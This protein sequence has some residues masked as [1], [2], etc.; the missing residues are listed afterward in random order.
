MQFNFTFDANV[1]LEQRVGFEMAA[2][3]WSKLLQD[4]VAV[5]LRIGATDQLGENGQ[6]VGGAIPI[7]HDTHYGTYQQYLANDITTAE[8][9]EVLAAL[10]AG[11]TVDVSVNGEIVDGNTELMLTRAQAKALGMEEAL[12][13]EDGQTWDRDV[14]A[15]PDGLDGYILINTSFDWHYDLTREA[16]AP[17]GTLDFL[18]MALHEIGHSL[19]FV[20]GL[21]GLIDTF[22]MHSGEERT[23][24]ITSLDL[25]RHADGDGIADLTFGNPAYFSIDGG[26]TNLA[27]FEEGNEYQASHWQ[28]YQDALGI[29]DPTLGYQE[30]TDISD[31]DLTAL[32]AIGWDVDYETL[33]NG[34]DLDTLY[35]QAQQSVAGTFGVNVEA[36]EAALTS[37]QDWQSLGYEAWFN[38]FK[39]QIM[40]QGWGTWFQGFDNQIL[41]QGWGTWFAEFQDQLLEQG[42]GTWFAEF[43]D[44]LLEQGWGTWFQDLDLDAAVL[45][46]LWGTWFQALEG[47]VFEQ[48]W[49][50]WFQSFEQE[51]LN[52]LWGTWFQ[53]FEQQVL[54]QGWGTWF[55]SFEADMLNQSWGT[56]FQSFEADM[57]NQSWGTWFQDFDAELLRQGWG[58]WFQEFESQSLSQVWGTWFQEMDTDTLNQLWGT[59]FQT[60]DAESFNQTWGT[61]FQS[62]DADTF[63]QMWGTWFQK[64]DTEVLNQM[65]GT[66]FQ[67]VDAD[68]FQQM[69]GTWFQNVD[70]ATLNQMWGTWFQ[71]VDEATL[72][73]MWGTWFQETDADTFQQM[74][75]TWFQNVDEATLNQMWGTWFQE[76]DPE[77]FQQG[78]GTWFQN[79]DEATLNQMWGTWFQETDAAA[80]SQM[81]GTWFQETDAA[82]FSQMWGTWFQTADT[83]TFDQMWGTWFQTVDTATFN[84]MWGTWFQEID[85]ATFDQMW[86]TWFQSVD[87]ATFNQMWGTW[88]Q[89]VDAD[90]LNQMWGTW[91]QDIDDGLLEQGW[92]TWFQK[93][94]TEV[95]EQG[96]GTWFQQIEGHSKTLDQATNQAEITGNA[97]ITGGATDDI[98]AGGNINDFINGV[99]GD[100]LIDGKAGDDVIFGGDGND[101]A[102]GW[103]GKD[104]IFGGEG[105]DFIAGENEDDQLY[106]EAGH[107]IMAGGRGDDY[108]DGGAGRDALKGDTGDDVLNGGDGEDLVD[109]GSGADLVIGGVGKDTVEGGMGD[110]I[111]YG[112]DYFVPVT[113][114]SNAT[115][116]PADPTISADQALAD[117]GF[118]MRLEA[119]DMKLKNYKVDD[120]AGASGGNV[121]KTQGK[122]RAETTFNGPSGTYDL[123]V[124]YEDQA[125]GSAEITL[126][127]KGK[128]PKQKY[129]WRLDGSA[130]AGTHTLSGITL[131]AG[132]EITLKGKSDRDT[133][134][135]LLD[136]LDIVTPGSATG[137]GTDPTAP[138]VYEFVAG[139]DGQ[140]AD[141]RIETEDMV[142]GGGYTQFD[143]V[144]AS[145]DAVVHNVTGE[146]GTATYTYTGETGVYNLYANYFDNI[147]G[148][149][150]AT[151]LLNGETLHSWQFNRDDFASHDE[152]LGLNVT[153]NQGD[154]IEI[155]GNANGL[156]FAAIDYITLEAV[157]PLPSEIDGIPNIETGTVV[158]LEAEQM[159]V[160]GGTIRQGDFAS[161]GGYVETYIPSFSISSDDD[162]DD[163]DDDD[164]SFSSFSEIPFNPLLQATSLFSGESGYYN[165]VVG[166]YDTT[167]GVAEIALS[168]DNQEVDR[169]YADQDF[170]D[171][172]GTNSLVSRTVAKGI[173]IEQFDLIE[174]SAIADGSDTGNIDYIQFIQVEPPTEITPDVPDVEAEVPLTPVNNDVIRGGEGHDTAYGGADDDTIYG[175]AGDDI[176]YGDFAAANDTVDPGPTAGLVGHW[177]FDEGSGFQAEDSTGTHSGTLLTYMSDQRSSSPWTSGKM[178]GGLAF[179]GF[180]DLVVV[181]D[182]DA[183]NLSNTLTLATWVK[184]D[185]FDDWNGLIVK[186]DSD[187]AYGLELASNGGLSFTANYGSL[188]G[189]VGSGDWFSNGT[190]TTDQWHHVAVTYDGS[191][192]Q[193]YID[194]ELDSSFAES[195]LT[196]GNSDDHLL[197]GADLAGTHFD[198][199][200]DDARVYNRALNVAEI[201]QLAASPQN[202]APAPGNAGTSF[203]GNDAL[204]FDHSNEMLINEGTLSFSFEADDVNRTQGLFSKDSSGYDDGGHLNIELNDGWLVGR[205]QTHRK[206]YH[207]A[208]QVEAGQAYDVAV[209]FG[210]R[211]IE[212]WLNGALVSN[213]NKTWGLG[214]NSGGSGN[215]EPIVLGATQTRSG[216]LVAD[217]LREYFTGT[218]HNVRLYDQQLSNVEIPQLPTNRASSANVVFEALTT[219]QGG[220][221]N[222]VSSA[223]PLENQFDGDDVRIFDHKTAM[224]LDDGTLSFRFQADS[225]SGHQGLISKDS[226]DYDDGGHFTVYLE[227]GQLIARFQ[228]THQTYYTSTWVSSGQDYDVAIT[229][230]DRGLELWLNG[231]LVDT[232]SYTGGLGTSAGGS[233]NREPIV[234]G[235]NQWASGNESADVLENHFS[236]TLQNVRLY[237]QQLSSV[238]IA[239][240]PAN[241]INS[242]N[243]VFEALTS[244]PS[245]QG[246]PGN[247]L[248]IGGS[249]NDTLFGEVGDDTLNGT[250]ADAAGALEIDTLT[251]GAGADVFILGDTQTAYYSTGGNLDY[252][253]ITDFTNGIDTL[254]L[255]GSATDYQQSTQGSDLFL[256]YGVDLVAQFQHL[257]LLDLNSSTTFV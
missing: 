256:Y 98:L 79:V 195:N 124:G 92:G 252:A 151:V 245:V 208:A 70:E 221:G 37:G 231:T 137:S 160:F 89:T 114:N 17:E 85:A 57:L 164:G 246:E 223:L 109:G 97:A 170:A 138:P 150:S 112:D 127:V 24:G 177:T 134:L 88:F 147:L 171:V 23:E 125:G 72:N 216:D 20:S 210:D 29:M 237:D 5:N 56:W 47:Q 117:L 76:T 51:M 39:E 33:A 193:F 13:L 190:I 172:A 173:A 207:I 257:T 90:T 80:F 201:G 77:L 115:N 149:A 220:A 200:L 180:N 153:L 226:E 212:L 238:E 63:S 121:I 18:T 31:L 140:Q 26:Q 166:Y 185:S 106:G 128:G 214:T 194:G 217:D 158:T 84:Q 102:Y 196:F 144:Y 227:S 239:Q 232:N 244:T 248:I 178:G 82:A 45:D 28:R 27:E 204:V 58:T 247:D 15:N 78:W 176:L 189:A 219:A 21:D 175:E 143:S 44:Q 251:G 203:S 6:A 159:N 19:G 2:A 197:L 235:A 8:D 83:A 69:W 113:D 183:L 145:G 9:Q 107:D 184:A 156:D 179:N 174:L 122:G 118:A 12:V 136:Y 206:Q 129:T 155:Q 30:R 32:D 101:I 52:Q 142:L 211:G 22:T 163:D 96:W 42:W 54:E 4:D 253:V 213:S 59:W 74:W 62:M 141:I 10:Q 60:A 48:M 188:S 40:E 162:G 7:F 64:L 169:W 215:R 250:D 139:N 234:L 233:G 132:D 243:V 161:G 167:G 130:G 255:H 95:L 105:D 224:L 152:T 119:E 111:L 68:T 38:A 222:T 16:D 87:E 104:T 148:N 192:V 199:T 93:F 198:G 131:E 43:Q 11:N 66:W 120:Q 71:S 165:I 67:N 1:S 242:A 126:E 230:G 103:H 154:V 168:V 181:A 240:L 241:P 50:T 86:G 35:E 94:E 65:W 254:Q 99:G 225:V 205:F 100:D 133:D 110:D 249:G 218:L 182:A 34:L 228:N 123:I 55:Q 25:M 187:I 135:A 61:W 46:Q 3:I 108:I 41:E 236:G 14:L 229:F 209:T 75:G 53:D 202:V 146:V 157:E 81:W 91:F 186:G 49:G 73:Q 36:V 191:Q 116:T